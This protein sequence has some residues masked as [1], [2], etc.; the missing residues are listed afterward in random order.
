[1]E[2]NPTIAREFK[3][4]GIKSQVYA[5]RMLGQIVFLYFLQ[6]K[7]WLGVQRGQKWGTGS[8]AFLKELFATNQDQDFFN[9]FLNPLFYDALATD[10][11]ASDHFFKLLGCRIPFLNGGLFEPLHGYD[12]RKFRL[13]IPNSFFTRLFEVFDRFNFTVRE[14]EPL[15][16]EVAVD[17]EML[18]KVFEKL[19]NVEERRHKGTYYTPRPIVHYMCR[20]SL[21]LYL[22]RALNLE[23][24]YESKRNVL[25]GLPN[26]A[27]ALALPGIKTRE[28]T[29]L[30]LD[31]VENVPLAD[32]EALLLQD[33]AIADVDDKA[34]NKKK[35]SDYSTELSASLPA[36]V[37]KNARRMDEALAKIKI[38]DPAIGSGAF[39]VGMMHEIVR[40]RLALRDGCPGAGLKV[41]TPYELKRETIANSLYGVDVDPS[42]IDVAKLR[43]WLS[44]VVDETD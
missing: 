31:R 35:A 30:R 6:K 33:E 32:I 12:W 34:D 39:A 3:E 25:P 21:A 44:L 9:D 11:S 5:K 4:K 14:D 20:E 13:H 29:C 40:L 27:G 43:L 22:D 16:S 19:L 37:Q 26:E 7:G 24:V 23:P 28:N 8:H 41:C 15:E 42:A 18:G 1:M 10:R 17:P 2:N 38:C 36:T